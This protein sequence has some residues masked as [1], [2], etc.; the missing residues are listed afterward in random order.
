METKCHDVKK[1][2]DCLSRDI[3]GEDPVL[4]K[5]KEDKRRSF[6]RWVNDATY[7]YTGALV[8]TAVDMPVL[9]K[10][11]LMKLGR[12]YWTLIPVMVEILDCFRGVEFVSGLP[13]MCVFANLA[14]ALV[15]RSKPAVP[16]Q[17]GMSDCMAEAKTL[18]DNLSLDLLCVNGTQRD[19]KE[20]SK[21][22]SDFLDDV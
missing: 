9:N 20:Q 4:K 8:A 6:Y 3:A 12:Q 1:A 7:I 2:F 18:F 15:S 11:A 19:Q 13:I 22:M 16:Y 21:D 5:M 17:D 10:T 14:H